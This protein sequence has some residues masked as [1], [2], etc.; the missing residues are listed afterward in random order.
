VYNCT[1]QA[2]KS[3]LK[4]SPKDS[5]EKQEMENK[6]ESERF[7]SVELKSR[8]HLKN[9]TLTNDSAESALIEGTLGELVQATFAEDVILEVVGTKGT[10][11]INLAQHEIK[12]AKKQ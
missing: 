1:S 11:R 4:R 3:N 9:V 8:T 6:I 10:F 7:F 5:Q 12:E 2:N